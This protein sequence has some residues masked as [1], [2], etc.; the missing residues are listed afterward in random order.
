MTVR[1]CGLISKY[2]SKPQNIL[3]PTLL[4]LVDLIIP[5]PLHVHHDLLPGQGG[6]EEQVES[7]VREVLS[8]SQ[9][10]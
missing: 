4:V 10:C 7:L 2:L 3:L 9:H 6:L 1:T 8:L 5:D